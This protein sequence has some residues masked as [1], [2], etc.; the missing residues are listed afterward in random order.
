MRNGDAGFCTSR[1]L[2]RLSD[3][4]TSP[5]VAEKVVAERVA[6]TA[7]EVDDVAGYLERVGLIEYTAVGPSVALTHVGVKEYECAM[8]QPYTPT[9]FFPPVNITT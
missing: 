4:R 3:G 2:Y 9:H 1:K 8:L 7:Q 6:W 5:S